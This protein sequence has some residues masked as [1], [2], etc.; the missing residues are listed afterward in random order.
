MF[1]F[2]RHTATLPF[3]VEV[4]PNFHAVPLCGVFIHDLGISVFALLVGCRLIAGKKFYFLSGVYTSYTNIYM[5][6]YLY[7]MHSF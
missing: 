3:T 5:P 6:L 7:T 4:R 2:E 1:T